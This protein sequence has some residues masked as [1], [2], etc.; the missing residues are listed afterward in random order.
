MDTQARERRFSVGLRKYLL[1]V[2]VV[3][4]GAAVGVMPAVAGSEAAP[5]IEA[6]NSGA[7]GYYHYWVPSS[8]HI[9]PGGSVTFSNPT[10][11]AHGVHWISGPGTPSC[12]GSVP[13]GT[14]SSSSG[15]SWSGSCSFTAAGVY[16][17]YCTVHG[18]A[19][20][21]TV[22]VEAGGTTTSTGTT[23]TSPTSTTPT[24]TT[25]TETTGAPA[26][27][28]SAT[29][30][31]TPAYDALALGAHARGARLRGS[32]DVSSAGAGGTLTV[33]VRARRSALAASARGVLAIGSYVRRN[34]PAGR[35]A[36]MVGL[37]RRARAALARRGRLA[38]TVVVALTPPAGA[39]S[40]VTRAL[41]LRS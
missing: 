29:P 37:S 26:G 20:S 10:A 28:G 17:F 11:V 21:G 36:F 4:L 15:T 39:A 18:A 13:V 32:L 31:A 1:V 35:I 8:A 30:G 9:A 14:T 24:A 16:T 25:G 40:S 7:G 23:T 5:A 27:P 6:V 41:T 33:S 22:T 19:M 2:L 12:A 3:A 38:V 34:V